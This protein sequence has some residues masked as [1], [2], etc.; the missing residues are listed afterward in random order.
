M[1]SVSEFASLKPGG[2]RSD[3]GYSKTPGTTWADQPFV[4]HGSKILQTWIKVRTHRAMAFH[5]CSRRLALTISLQSRIYFP[6][7][8]AERIHSSDL[9]RTT[10]RRLKQQMLKRP[11]IRANTS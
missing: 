11:L 10:R 4:T 9:S 6:T 2:D 8:E 1:V 5:L 7:K 3:K